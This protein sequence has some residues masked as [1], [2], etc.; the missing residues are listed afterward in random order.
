MP[1]WY[2]QIAPVFVQGVANKYVVSNPLGVFDI[3][4][5]VPTQKMTGYLAKYTKADWFK[6][7]TPSDYLRIGATESKGDNFTV[8]KQTYRVQPYSFH[9]DV[10]KDDAAEYDNPFDPVND[11]TEFVINRINRILLKNLSDTYLA[12]GIWDG[13]HDDTAAQWDT[14]SSGVNTVDPVEVVLTRRQARQAV[15]GYLPNRMIITPD[16]FK[17][18]QTNTFILDR[19]KVTDTKIVTEALLASLFG[20]STLK[21]FDAVNADATAY[22]RT[23]LCFLCYTPDRATKFAPSA[24]YHMTYQKQNGDVVQ[25]KQIMM[26]WLNDCLR[27]EGTVYTDPIVVATDLGDYTYNLV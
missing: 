17:A 24:G 8:A 26:E 21:V 11:A 12:T 5:K 20:V 16:V 10:T 25:T 27:V 18:L 7:G 19:M 6:I 22:L 13:E 23:G 2:D 14:K 3:F 4:P 15:T 9:N 1:H